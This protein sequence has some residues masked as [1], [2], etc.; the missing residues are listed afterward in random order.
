MNT[1]INPVDLLDMIIGLISTWGLKVIGAIAAFIL[2]RIAAGWLRRTMHKVLERSQVDETLIPFLASL[3]YYA[4]LAFVIIAVLGIVGIETA[5]LAVVLGAAGLAVGLALQGT[6]SNFASGVMLMIFHPIKLGDWVEIGGV[7]GSVAELG[8]FS[9]KLNTGD[10][11]HIVIPNSNVYGETISNYSVNDIRRVDLAVGIHYEDDIGLAIKTLQKILDEDERVIDEPEPMIAV[12]ELADS[13]VNI[14]VRPWCNRDN[15]WRLRCDLTR[16]FKEELEE[17]GCSIPF[18]QHDVHL[19]R[20]EA[21][22][23]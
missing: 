16:K 20:T 9:T 14:L 5:S 3:V 22:A 18:P 21:V 1:G 10:N 13:S 7:A 11:V 15:Y 8:I 17:A 12:G 19:Y 4:T 2:G 23:G 6:L